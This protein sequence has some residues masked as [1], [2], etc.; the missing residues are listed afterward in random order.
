MRLLTGYSYCDTAQNGRSSINFDIYQRVTT[1]KV[2]CY[3]ATKTREAI[4]LGYGVKSATIPK[5]GSIAVN[6]FCHKSLKYNKVYTAMPFCS[7]LDSKG[8][9]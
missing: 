3:T 2:N 8:A 6:T 5:R 4:F 1:K 9:K 7:S